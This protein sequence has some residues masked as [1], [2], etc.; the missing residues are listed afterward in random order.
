MANTKPIKNLVIFYL[1]YFILLPILFLYFTF[2]IGYI[3]FYQEN[4][5]LFLFSADYLSEHLAKPGSLLVYLGNFLTA[6]YYY[7]WIGALIV[8]SV[9]CLIAL[10]VTRILKVYTNKN[11][12]I[13]PFLIAGALFFLQSSYQF[14]LYN[15]LGIFLQLVIFYLTLK[16]LKS[17]KGWLAV[18]LFP[19][20]YFLTGGFAW[21]FALL[22]SVHLV[23]EKENRG[24]Q[25]IIV[26]WVI[27]CLV[28][29]CSKEFLF[30][31]SLKELVMFPLSGV[32]T[33]F[34]N[35]VYSLVIVLIGIQP[36]TK[37]IKPGIF[38]KLVFSGN[39]F[40]FVV[41]L[42]I[43][44]VSILLTD[45]NIDKRNKHYFIVEK[46]FYQG[47][48][49]E[50][51]AFNS[52]YP[53][54][55][56]LTNYFNNIALAETGRLNDLLFHFP[57]SPDGKTLFLEWEIVGEV[58][59]RGA[60][61]YYTVGMIN[62]AHRWAYEYMVMRGYTPEGLKMLIKTELINGN[63]KIASKYISILK[64]SLFYRKDAK[65][66]EKLLFNE[67]AINAHSEY[68]EKKKIRVSNDFFVMSGEPAQ[69]LDL[70]LEQDSSNVMAFE[71]KLA[72]LLLQKDIEKIVEQLP[73]MQS[74][75]YARIPR[76]VEE[77]AV[78]YKLL[79]MGDFPDTGTLS[80]N[81]ETENQFNQ[82]YRTF[83]QF[84]NDPRRAQQPL[85]NRFGNTFWYYV[86]YN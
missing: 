42:L 25:K 8:S 62:E 82:Y 13:L 56:Q 69:N 9:I 83:S 61:F 75:G 7:P 66:F 30:Y 81:P 49:E 35:I 6:F 15:T 33:G 22:F 3:F 36:L 37:L 43:I 86:F 77:A 46:L 74:L 32:M 68:G 10:Y 80:I 50:I 51:I 38:K 19:V 12:V 26:F 53:S 4:S 78:S 52:R 20:W 57:Q 21:I 71:Y 85:F 65:E 47:K 16:T 45:Q 2:F 28:L 84:G 72:S 44:G 64:K 1:P 70:I 5:S 60:Y 58:L 63:Y 24:W 79:R 39:A 18:F 31:Q 34:Q 11:Q 76:H 14:L 23:L 17:L 29:L 59:K 40:K 27:N 54:Y 48:F 41:P 67:E 73:R 55:N